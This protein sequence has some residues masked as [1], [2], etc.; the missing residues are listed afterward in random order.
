MSACDVFF[1]IF[2]I[3]N[4]SLG[5]AV[6]R[7]GSM[8]SLTGEAQQTA[9]ASET[10]SGRSGG[11]VTSKLEAQLKILMTSTGATSPAEV[12]QRFTAQK[13]ASSRLNYLR[14]VTEGEKKHLET[15]RD[16]LM[17]QL[18]SFKFTDIKENEM[19]VEC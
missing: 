19:Y 17:S 3:L 8:D 6:V 13:E 16:N 14:T 4:F 12:L 5:R 10:A 7:Q 15:Q 9:K 18:E 11:D 1:Y 2:L